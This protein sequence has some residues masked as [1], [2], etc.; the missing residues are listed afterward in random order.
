MR[1]NSIK[2]LTNGILLRSRNRNWEQKLAEELR[3]AIVIGII[4]WKSIKDKVKES[5]CGLFRA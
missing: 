4:L 2:L 5:S 3:L 1:L